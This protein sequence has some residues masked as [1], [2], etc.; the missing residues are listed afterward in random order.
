M[1]HGVFFR[2]AGGRQIVNPRGTNP[3]PP[4]HL[5]P[6]CLL[7]VECGSMDEGTAGGEMG[8]GAQRDER[9]LHK[10]AFWRSSAS[11]TDR[12]RDGVRDRCTARE[13]RDKETSAGT[14]E[15]RLIWNRISEVAYELSHHDNN[16]LKPAFNW[17][18][19]HLSVVSPSTPCVYSI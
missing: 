14:K 8:R 1:K 2:N 12:G 19:L 15:Q 9:P 16:T 5:V 18:C 7:T 3:P 4:L 13:V 10:P 6:L 17:C 11:R